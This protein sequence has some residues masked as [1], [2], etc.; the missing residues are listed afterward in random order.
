M[1]KR[2]EANL[3]VKKRIT[4]ALFDLMHEKK[5]N[6]ITVTEIITSAKVARVSFYRN[7]ASKEKVL[8]GLIDDVLQHFLG[9]EDYASVDYTS[10][11]HI[12][13]CFF[14]FQ[15]YGRYVLDLYHSEF[16][17]VLL[18]ELNRFHEAVAGYM[19]A[20]SA[21]KYSVY[22]YMGAL[23]NSAIKWLE[24]GMKESID[25][26]SQVFCQNAGIAFN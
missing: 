25:E 11:A 26:I 9:N 15:E 10:Y 23:F 24:S 16:A 21:T 6:E 22:M 19:P 2:K 17:T 14:Y 13:K 4:D 5:F 20:K 8:T 7:F 3:K 18:D 12:K 1:D